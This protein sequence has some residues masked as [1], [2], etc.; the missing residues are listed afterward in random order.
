MEAAGLG[1][2]SLL[3]RDENQAFVNIAISLR[4]NFCCTISTVEQASLWLSA[5]DPRRSEDTLCGEQIVAGV[6]T[7][8]YVLC[9]VSKRLICKCKIPW[10]PRLHGFLDQVQFSR[11]PCRLQRVTTAV[12][13]CKAYIGESFSI[14][15]PHYSTLVGKFESSERI[16]EL[17]Y[18]T[19]TQGRSKW[20][21]RQWFIEV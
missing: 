12:V 11:N 19:V 10:S 15:D 20:S 9:H 18:L 17:P 6:M 3:P 21:P 16:L 1:G 8:F 2:N 7:S 14:I 13:F 5:P 4:L